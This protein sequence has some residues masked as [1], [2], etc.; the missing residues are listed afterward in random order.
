[1]LRGFLASSTSLLLYPHVPPGR[2]RTRRSYNRNSTRITRHVNHDSAAFR[3]ATTHP[4]SPSPWIP[5]LA[6]VVFAVLAAL[7]L[8]MSAAPTWSQAYD[9]MGSWLISTLVASIP[10]I[11]L[12]GA[13]ASTKVHAHWAAVLGLASAMLVAVFA[14]HMPGKMAAATQ[15]M[16]PATA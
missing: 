12:L 10:V 2:A 1:M 5:L 8:R 9:P 14:F 4:K 15:C 7:I 16:E 3:I 11:V 6:A 13:L